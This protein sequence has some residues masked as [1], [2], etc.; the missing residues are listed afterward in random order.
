MTLLL[1][2]PTFCLTRGLIHALPQEM[3]IRLHFLFTEARRHYQRF[4]R[5][6]GSPAK[7]IGHTQAIP[8]AGIPSLLISYANRHNVES[9]SG[10]QING[11]QLHLAA[12]PA[13]PVG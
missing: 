9:R 5:N 8:T 1:F 7:W 10:S 2:Q 12:R 11:S 6:P 3:C 4:S 13:R